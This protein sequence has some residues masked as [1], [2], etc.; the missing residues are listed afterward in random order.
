MPGAAATRTRNLPIECVEFASRLLRIARRC[1]RAR[2]LL[3]FTST[4]KPGRRKAEVLRGLLGSVSGI[5]TG[6][7]ATAP[8][9]HNH[10]QARAPKSWSAPWYP[11]AWAFSYA[12][13]CFFSIGSLAAPDFCGRRGS[14]SVTVPRR[15]EL[16][17]LHFIARPRGCI[18]PDKLTQLFW[19]PGSAAAAFV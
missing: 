2:R 6:T 8:L 15:V 9:F 12:V 16:A 10:A 1:A 13:P 7:S 14:N 5:L 19:C 3:F 4:P 18:C 17:V 11:A